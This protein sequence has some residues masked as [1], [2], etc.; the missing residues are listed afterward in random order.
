MKTSTVILMCACLLAASGLAAETVNIKSS[1]PFVVVNGQYIYPQQDGIYTIT[2]T[3]KNVLI[4]GKIYVPAEKLPV[5]I[6]KPDREKDFLDWAVR[7]PADSAQAMIDAGGTF[8][9]ASQ[10]MAEFYRPFVGSDTFFVTFADGCYRLAYRGTEVYVSV[11]CQKREPK[12]DY[13]ENVLVPAF[14]DL[15]YHLQT[16]NLVFKGEGY[17]Q[18]IP[19]HE[20]SPSLLRQIREITGET[21]RKAAGGYEEQRLDGPSGEICLLP[22]VVADLVKSNK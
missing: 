9:Q 12:P 10:V 13:R 4:Q 17:R 5:L 11:P 6:P 14:T 22:S 2:L 3:E 21:A 18:I 7:V 16:G 1:T 15:C 8:E 20:L 19:A